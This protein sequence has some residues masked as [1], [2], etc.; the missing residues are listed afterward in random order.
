MASS[1]KKG[2]GRSFQKVI[3]GDQEGGT[4]K[5]GPKMGDVI[6]ECSLTGPPGQKGVQSDIQ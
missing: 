1:F 4:S 2:G 3:L 6:Y 5:K